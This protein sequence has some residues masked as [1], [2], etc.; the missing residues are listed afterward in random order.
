[1]AEVEGVRAKTEKYVNEHLRLKADGR[2]L[3]G[4]LVWAEYVQRP[5][6]VHEQGL[7]QLRLVYPPVDGAA[8]LSG[9]ADF[10]EDYRQERIEGKQPIA[11]TME[12]RTILKIPGRRSSRFE[13]K[14]GA[15]AFQLSVKDAERT[16]AQR[17][18]ESLRTGAGTAMASVFSVTTSPLRASPV[19]PAV[20]CSNCT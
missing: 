20:A 10:F 12:F 11:P 16:A 14:P 9:E 3:A 4:R 5:W 19:S 7:F 1:M 6:E 8:A 13:L 15:D 17:A 18:F 2:P